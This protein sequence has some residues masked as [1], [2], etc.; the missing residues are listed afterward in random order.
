MAVAPIY[1]ELKKGWWEFC[2]I[3]REKYKPGCFRNAPRDFEPVLDSTQ[4]TVHA[5]T[6]RKFGGKYYR[7]ITDAEVVDKG[8]LRDLEL[9]FGPGDG[10]PL[11]FFG[12]KRMAYCRS[13]GAE[14][15]WAKTANGVDMPLDPAPINLR[16]ATPGTVFITDA[17]KTV[18]VPD[19]GL[20]LA[21]VETY[22]VCRVSHY[23]TCP[24]GAF[25]RK[26]K[27]FEVR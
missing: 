14:V 19:D 10:K 4:F 21:E 25:W 11:G 26:K 16:E 24:D 23:A 27:K 15:E 6:W 17:G 5:N 18:R 20:T 7:L 12:E 9:L 8:T 22:G 1:K 3:F 2:G 13:C